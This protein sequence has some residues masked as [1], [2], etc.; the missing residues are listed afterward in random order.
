[1]DNVVDLA[2]H[3]SHDYRLDRFAVGCAAGITTESD[4][5]RSDARS[6]HL[7]GIQ[8]TPLKRNRRT[9]IAKTWDVVAD[10]PVRGQ[11]IRTA[12]RSNFTPRI[13]L[14]P[15]FASGGMP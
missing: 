6:R 12:G 15:S 3:D 8:R 4:K 2:V 1:M 14:T 9:S 10:P 11:A 7:P 5:S 13:N